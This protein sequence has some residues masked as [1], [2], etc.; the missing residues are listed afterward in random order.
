[1]EYSTNLIEVF[2]KWYANI[3]EGDFSI[4][5]YLEHPLSK[6]STRRA[7]FETPIIF[8]SDIDFAIDRLGRK[9]V[10]LKWCKDIWQDFKGYKLNYK[11]VKL[12]RYIQSGGEEDILVDS[13]IRDLSRILSQG[14][15]I[16]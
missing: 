8:K 4:G 9:G 15:L 11:Q 5:E 3:H 2:L 16:R 12:A 13:L 6:H 14:D 7:A 10:W 1:M